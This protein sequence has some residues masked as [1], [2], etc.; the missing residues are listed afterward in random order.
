M[1]N[2]ADNSR[3]PEGFDQLANRIADVYII[4]HPTDPVTGELSTRIQDL[5]AIAKLVD[6]SGGVETLAIQW[7]CENGLGQQNIW[8]PPFGIEPGYY[9][10]VVDLNRDGRYTRGVDI[11]DGRL[12]NKPLKSYHYGFR[13][14]NQG[15]GQGQP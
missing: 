11:V 9:D 13:T 1:D 12:S 15:Q 6:V 5:E 10:V 4:K 3:L 14:V 2:A 8:Q 7:G